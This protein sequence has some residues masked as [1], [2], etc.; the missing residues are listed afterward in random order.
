MF[1]KLAVLRDACTMLLDLDSQ[2]ILTGSMGAVLADFGNELTVLAHSSLANPGHP[3]MQPDHTTRY[4]SSAQWKWRTADLAALRAR[5]EVQP[6]PIQ[7]N[8]RWAG[9]ASNPYLLW[10]F[11]DCL[12]EHYAQLGN[13]IYA[14]APHHAFFRLS[15]RVLSQKSWDN[16][17]N[18]MNHNRDGVSQRLT[19]SRPSSEAT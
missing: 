2:S 16:V 1:F 11:D 14:F 4:V 3:C 13:A 9:S 6:L 8:R 5:E 10:A 19:T 17:V 12:Q 18:Q 7:A 15:V